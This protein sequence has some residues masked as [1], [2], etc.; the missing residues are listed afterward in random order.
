MTQSQK[1]VERE[2]IFGGPKQTEE[3]VASKIGPSKSI[4]KDSECQPMPPLSNIGSTI[5]TMLQNNVIFPAK[6]RNKLQHNKNEYVR[7]WTLSDFWESSTWPR[8]SSGSG[9][10]RF[11]LP[12]VA[13]DDPDDEPMIAEAP[14]IQTSKS[15]KTKYEKIDPDNLRAAPQPTQENPYVLNIAGVNGLKDEIVDAELD[16]ILFLSA[17]FCKTCKALGPQYTRLARIAKDENESSVSFVKAEASGPFGKELGR[18]LDVKA[19]P[20]FLLFRKGQRYGSLMTTTKLPSKKIDKA[21]ELLESGSDW[22]PS[23]LK[24]QDPKE[25]S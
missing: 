16:C 21:I 4:L 18:A 9:G 10:T 22:D 5:Q 15:K 3:Y 25:E 12:V 2:G 19:V 23:I 20:T 7:G 24:I 11:G 6:H 13:D 17:R 1:L 8:D 14:S